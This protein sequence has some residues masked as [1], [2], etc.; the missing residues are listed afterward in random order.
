MDS[1]TQA[2][3]DRHVSLGRWVFPWLLGFWWARNVRQCFPP[4]LKCGSSC[5]ALRVYLG[6]CGQ[7]SVCFRFR[8]QCM[9]PG[10]RSTLCVVRLRSWIW[11]L[12]FFL[13]CWTVWCFHR[14]GT[15][16]GKGQILIFRTATIHLIFTI[17][18][19]VTPRKRLSYRFSFACLESCRLSRALHRAGP[20]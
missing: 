3:C 15:F 13:R 18:L 10:R 7:W 2:R 16:L 6:F 4:R 5:T 9:A 17:F 11:L 19:A 20:L 12:L 14:W 1:R 8:W